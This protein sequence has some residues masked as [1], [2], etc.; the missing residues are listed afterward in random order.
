L[1]TQDR[2]EIAKKQL[3]GWGVTAT[4]GP[5]RTTAAGGTSGGTAIA[6]KTGATVR[7]V[8][9]LPASVGGDRA[10]A[11]VAEIGQHDVVL[12]TIYGFD[13]RQTLTF[14][15]LELFLQDLVARRLPICLGGDCKAAARFPVGVGSTPRWRHTARTWLCCDAEFISNQCQK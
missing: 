12:G 10:Q 14:D 13:G 4:F 11:I 1:A 9:S 7:E 15:L 2:I 6:W 3:R 5:A 8:L